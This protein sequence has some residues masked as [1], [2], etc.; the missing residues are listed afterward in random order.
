MPFIFLASHYMTLSSTYKHPIDV[1]PRWDFS[2]MTQRN[3]IN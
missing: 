3:G 1:D 2:L